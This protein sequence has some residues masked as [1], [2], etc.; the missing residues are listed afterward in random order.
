MSE[1]DLY[2]VVTNWM[3]ANSVSSESGLIDPDLPHFFRLSDGTRVTGLL[4]ESKLCLN[5][6][7]L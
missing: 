2:F 6:C 1:L 3:H 5:N 7:L 4:L